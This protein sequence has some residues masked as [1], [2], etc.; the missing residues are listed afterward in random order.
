MFKMIKIAIVFI[1]CAC[2]MSC[3]TEQ[4]YA[5][6]VHSWRGGTENDLYR[7]WGYPNR[8]EKLPN[9]HNLLVYKQVERGTNPVYSNPGS[10]TVQTGPN[11]Q[12]YVNTTPATV[13]GGGS[14]NYNCTTWFELDNTGTIIGTNFRGNNCVANQSFIRQYSA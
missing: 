9:G 11:G 5:L 10:T 1:C 3:A 12:T 2:I 13:S 6:A 14:Y 7:V 8:V 4:N